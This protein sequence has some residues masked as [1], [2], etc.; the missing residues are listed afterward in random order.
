MLGAFCYFERQ[1]FP[2][3]RIVGLLVICY[4]DLRKARQ[5]IE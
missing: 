4:R 2:N 1:Y 5:Y 3:S